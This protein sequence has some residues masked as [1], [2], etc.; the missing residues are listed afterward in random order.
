M[1]FNQNIYYKNENSEVIVKKYKV[2]KIDENYKYI[3]KN[4]FY[5]IFSFVTYW[6]VA[7]PYAFI[8]FKI[9]KNT[10]FHNKNLLKKHKKNGYFIY[11]NH[12][13]QYGDGFCPG[14][15]CYPQKPHIIVNPINIAIPII[16]RFNRLCG[17]LPLPDNIKATKNFYIAISYTLEKNNPVVI[18]PEAHLWPYYTK[19]R[20]F[21]SSS[22]RY[23]VKFNK[24]VFTFTTIFKKK[25]LSKKPKVEIYVDGPFY[26]NKNLSEKEAQNELRDKVFQI[27]NERASLSNYN[28]VNYIQKE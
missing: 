19:I 28:Y 14:L 21:S 5:K 27:F 24:P 17:A 16:G 6:F 13:N 18:Y 23:P 11:A 10:K 4:I 9:L 20:N 7:F 3:H 26:P 2:K 1:K 12:V 25:K 15:I 8:V 22:F